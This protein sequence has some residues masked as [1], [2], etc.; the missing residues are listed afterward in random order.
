M[1]DPRKRYPTHVEA[2]IRELRA[3]G[4]QPEHWRVLDAIEIRLDEMAQEVEFTLI[5]HVEGSDDDLVW[6]RRVLASFGKVLKI[7]AV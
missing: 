2:L 7:T 3:Q 6:R 4:Q 1:V 5:Q